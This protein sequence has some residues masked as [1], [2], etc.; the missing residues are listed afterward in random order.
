MKLKLLFSIVLFSVCLFAQFKDT[1][2]VNIREGIVKN[3][4]SSTFLGFFNPQ[5]FSMHHSLSMSY[6]AGSN[7][8]LAL[9]IYTNTMGYKFTDNLNIEVDASLVNSP[10]S[11]FGDSFAKQINGLY[12]SRVSLNYQPTESTSVSLQFNQSPFGYYS[13]YYNSPFYFGR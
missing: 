10:Y 4:N 7:Y 5:N 12:L 6:S 8:G 11:T 13:G 9:G 2:P 3:E 1:K